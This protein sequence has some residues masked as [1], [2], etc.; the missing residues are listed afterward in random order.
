MLKAP[1]KSSVRRTRTHAEEQRHLLRTAL[2]SAMADTP[3][4]I[5]LKRASKAGLTLDER[6]DGLR[7][8]FKSHAESEFGLFVEK[9]CVFISD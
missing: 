3:Y 5:A 1:M 9:G 2:K 7:L 6:T 4:I 8:T